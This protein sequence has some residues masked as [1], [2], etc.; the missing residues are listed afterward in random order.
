MEESVRRAFVPL[1]LGARARRD[2]RGVVLLMLGFVVSGGS[3]TLALDGSRPADTVLLNGEILLFE[4]VEQLGPGGPP[5]APPKFAQALAITEGRIAW[6]GTTTEVRPH[7]GPGTKV[8]D[9]GGRM[10]MPGIIDGHFHGTR[11]TDCHLGYEGGT[12]PQILARLQACLDRGDQVAL[13]QTGTRFG[14]TYFFGEAIEPP[15]TPLTR[16]DLDRLDTTRPVLVRN[17]DGHKFWMNSRAIANASIDEKTP[18]PAGGTIGRDA[19]R[20]PNGFFA[21]Y[22]IGD[23]GPKAPVTEEARLEVV[24]RTNADANRAGINGRLRSGRRR[25]TRSRSGRSCRTTASSTLAGQPR[26]VGLL[27][28]RQPRSQRVSRRRSTPSASTSGTPRASSTSRASR[29]TATESWSTRP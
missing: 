27:R 5:P 19:N 9:L 23:W 4:G 15:G 6:I 1:R 14:A 16:Y 13:K 11:A 28:P 12:V 21:D 25:R 10:V 7:I 29:S 18:D 20:K 2:A 26:P 8:V 22:D 3:P 24:R 17:A